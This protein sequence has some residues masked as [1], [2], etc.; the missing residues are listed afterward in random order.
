[1]KKNILISILF[2]MSNILFSQEISGKWNWKY[3]NGAHLCEITLNKIGENSYEGY[4][5]SS[6]YEGKKIDCTFSETEICI[7]IQLVNEN[8]FEGSFVSP[9]FSGSGEIRLTFQSLND[10]LKI[11][12][13]NSENEFYLPSNV[14]F[15]R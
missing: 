5:C 4:Y 12:I 10:K 13:L 3:E 15:V 14:F 1:M 11:E 7:D 8:V 6:F 9:S 2:F